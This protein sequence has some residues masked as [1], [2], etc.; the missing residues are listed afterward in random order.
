MA[1]KGFKQKGQCNYPECEKTAAH[2]SLCS[3]HY[4]KSRVCSICTKPIHQNGLCRHHHHAFT[5]LGDPLAIGKYG[6]GHT[7]SQ[8]YRWVSI[9]GVPFREHRLVMEQAL[10][11][12]LLPNENVH[13]KDGNRSNNSLGNL[14]LWVKSQPKGQRIVDK[15]EYARGL[16]KLYSDFDIP[17]S[18]N[19]TSNKVKPKVELINNRLELSG[20]TLLWDTLNRLGSTTTMELVSTTGMTSSCI[21]QAARVNPELFVKFP[22]PKRSKYDHV[23]FCWKI[24]PGAKRPDNTLKGWVD[25][26]GYQCYRVNGKE[27]SEHRLVMEQH[28]GRKLLPK[29]N[30]HHK[31]GDRL[32]NDISNLELWSTS[33]PPGQR[34]P[35]LIK[36]AHEIIKL[37]G[38][39]KPE[40]EVEKILAPTRFERDP[41]I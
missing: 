29:E 22:N 13:H 11:R 38:Q 17:H 26:N 3:T 36:W 8:G 27:C 33:Q 31:D 40:S 25:E 39:T 23:S 20:A 1:T 28:L 6:S 32:N 10:G 37:Y 15:L 18:S 21:F 7:N 19:F 30:V 34:I 5:T 14:E 12:P 16:F 35:D 9:E 2:N 24:K 41:V 4:R